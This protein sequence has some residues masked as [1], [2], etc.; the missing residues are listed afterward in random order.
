MIVTNPY[1]YKPLKSITHAGGSRQ[2]V[3]PNGEKVASVTTILSKTKD[4]TFLK[5]WKKRVGEAEAARVV[6]RSTGLGTGM[7]NILENYVKDG[8]PPAGNIF[9]VGMAKKIINEG[10]SKV[11]EVWGTEVNLYAEGLYAGTADLVGVH[12][13]AETMMDYKN[14]RSFRKEEWVTDYKLQVVAYGLAHN[15]MHNTNIKKGVIMIATQ[16]GKY[17]EFVVE[18]ND[19]DKACSMW[20]ERLEK[21]YSM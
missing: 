18:G 15:E 8:T 9:S 12:Q 6:K 5:E 19:W 11:D 20:M 21:Y 2:Y 4:M 13:K 17:Q 1:E 3:T 7:H 14:S 16:D 10:L